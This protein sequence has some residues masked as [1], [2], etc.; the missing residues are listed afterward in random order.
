MSAANTLAYFAAASVTNGKETFCNVWISNEVQ[1]QQK[2]V[3]QTVVG[4][5]ANGMF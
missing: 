2:S 1:Q 5:L 3:K 4:L